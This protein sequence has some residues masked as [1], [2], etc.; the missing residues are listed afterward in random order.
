MYHQH[1]ML[2]CLF[3]VFDGLVFLFELSDSYCNFIIWFYTCAN[4][5][6]LLSLCIHHLS[7]A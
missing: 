7:G 3:K 6:N 1:N 2:F 5:E 4:R